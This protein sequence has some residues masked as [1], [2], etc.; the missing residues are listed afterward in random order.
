MTAKEIAD[1]WGV[2]LGAKVGEGSNSVVYDAVS[3]DGHLVVK[4][5]KGAK[6]YIS[7]NLQRHSYE[8]LSHIFGTVST[9]RG[10][11]NIKIVTPRVHFYGRRDGVGEVM[12]M[13][14]MA[15][16]FDI[17]LAMTSSLYPDGIVAGAV[18]A[19]IA[20]LHENGISGFDAE[21]YWDM[22]R[23]AVILLDVG[24]VATFG[25]TAGDMI[26]TH[27]DIERDNRMGKWNIVSQVLPLG[28]AKALYAADGF[29]DV[30]LQ[31]I[32][33]S[34][35]ANTAMRHIQD[36]AKVHA[37]SLFGRMSKE[38]KPHLLDAFVK[39]YRRN[40]T[41]STECND[42]Y[43]D[44]FQDAVLSGIKSGAACLY[45]PQK[46]ALSSESCTAVLQEVQ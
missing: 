12:V 26:S 23:D 2:V 30:P 5:T 43:I 21:F 27:W 8:C 18:G 34:L 40:T 44:T 39:E 35:D 45:Y 25:V 46:A 28:E 9:A 22:T 36:T 42:I 29:M 1:E 16:L 17:E 33:D 13:D 11:G 10:K 37:V 32:I 19:V 38:V 15:S 41:R 24:P 6:R 3:M 31:H 7:F 20:L 14:K 4:C